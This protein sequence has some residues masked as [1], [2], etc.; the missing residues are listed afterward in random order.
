MRFDGFDVF[1]A[2]WWVWC[3]QCVLM[4]L[5]CSMRFD[6]FDVFNAFWWVWCVQCLL[7]GLMCSMCFDGFDVFNAFW[8]VWCVQCVL[9]GLMC[10]MRFDGFDVFNVSEC[11]LMGLTVFDNCVWTLFFWGIWRVSGQQQTSEAIKESTFANIGSSDDSDFRSDESAQLQTDSAVCDNVMRCDSV[12]YSSTY[13]GIS[14]DKR[15]LHS[16]HGKSAT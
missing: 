11:V 5:M 10:S 3:V 12:R 16:R 7:M 13:G 2:F 15:R 6:G 4:G 9:M 8:W 1:N 14:V